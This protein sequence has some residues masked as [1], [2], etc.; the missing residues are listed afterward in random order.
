[1][2]ATQQVTEFDTVLAE[3]AICLYSTI[4]AIILA[5][6]YSKLNKYTLNAKM[7][8]VC[9]C[10]IKSRVY[11]MNFKSVQKLPDPQPQTI[12]FIGQVSCSKLLV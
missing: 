7:Y 6:G 3:L 9:F 4:L 12:H 2:S 5:L 8:L 11:Q 10:N 1:M